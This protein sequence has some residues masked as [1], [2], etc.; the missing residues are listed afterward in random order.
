MKRKIFKNARIVDVIQKKVY[1]GWFSILGEHFEFVE[2]GD[3]EDVLDGEVIDLKGLYVVPGFI[4]SH[5]HIESSLVTPKVFSQAVIP[6]GTVAVL[7]DPHEMANIL[8]KKGVEFMIDN[9]LGQPLE[10]Y[11]AIPS[12]VPTT[13]KHLETSNAELTPDDVKELSEKERVI[14]LG[15]VMDYNGVLEGD[16]KLLRILNIAREKNLSIEGHCP[17]LRRKD[18][19]YY[20][21]HGIRSDHTL[22]N[23]DKMEEQ[24]RKGMY[25]MIQRKS[26]TEE[27]IEFIMNL[28]DRSRI[29]MVTDDFL[30]SDLA[31]GHLNLLV[32]LAISRGWDPL[33]AISS[34]TIRPAVYLGLKHLGVISPGKVASFFLT[35]NLEKIR[36]LQVFIKGSPFALSMLK[37]T[38]NTEEFSN[39]IGLKHVRKE[40]FRVYK[41]GFN[42]YL[43]VNAILITSRENSVTTLSKL[44]LRFKDGYP[45][46]D[47]SEDV[48]MIS[49]F[50]RKET[51]PRGCV[52]F[53]KNLG[54]SK[55]AF[56]T[57]FAHDSHNI[58][59]V[60][61]DVTAMTMATNAIIKARGGMAVYMDGKTYLLE[62]PIGGLI[63]D[64]PFDKVLSK[65]Q[66]IEYKLWESGIN[67]KEPIKLLSVLALT[68]SPFYKIS[69]LGIVDVERGKLL[70]VVL[71]EVK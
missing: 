36:P 59:V 5:M 66:K 57:T 53:V 4:D 9:A 69:D 49:V 8:G 20:L 56:A 39:S 46:M 23:P 31:K 67:H 18:L 22:T 26:L 1:K 61:K 25:V 44:T 32:N 42:G 64:E 19:S 58:L 16:E 27:N 60:G 40:D 50:R 14:A 65:F 6:H 55:G 52:G 13:R 7:Q 38:K 62:L 48:A 68:V 47:S 29:L 2:R 10:I 41:K 37:D 45:I 21:Y 70:P 24:L 30:P 17:T 15:E 71:K 51:S 11:T 63:T 43:E 12:C 28:K 33:D 34:V 3:Y 54:L 35:E